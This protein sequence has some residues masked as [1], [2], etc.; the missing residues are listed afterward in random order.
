MKSGYTS[1]SVV[2]ARPRA[3]PLFFFF[4]PS[5]FPFFP[6]FRSLT[7]IELIFGLHIFA[8]PYFPRLR[9]YARPRKI[10]GE[11]N[12]WSRRLGAASEGPVA[13]AEADWPRCTP[14]CIGGFVTWPECHF[15][16]Y[17]GFYSLINWRLRKTCYFGLFRV[18]SCLAQKTYKTCNFG[19]FTWIV[20]FGPFW[21]ISGHFGF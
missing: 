16:P 2:R 11:T 5:F 3:P 6:F 14:E 17:F 10:G 9:A 1:W 8:S 20:L 18:I 19:L 7:T 4:F 15:W 12:I 21:A 13:A